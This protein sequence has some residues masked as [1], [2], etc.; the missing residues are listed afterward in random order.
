ML[1]KMMLVQW[2]VLFWGGKNTFLALHFGLYFAVLSALINITRISVQK[3]QTQIVFQIH[4]SA[5]FLLKLP[6]NLKL[7]VEEKDAKVCLC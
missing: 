1:Q 5:N 7:L 6:S 3:K 2:H 4:V